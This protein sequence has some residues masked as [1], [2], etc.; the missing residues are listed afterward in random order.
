MNHNTLVEP[1]ENSDES[2]NAEIIN[3]HDYK[4]LPQGDIKTELCQ[5]FAS[6]H[7]SFIQVD[8]FLQESVIR[9]CIRA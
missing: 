1:T 9:L 2:L 4:M 7:L 5:R 3:Q 8:V 6:V